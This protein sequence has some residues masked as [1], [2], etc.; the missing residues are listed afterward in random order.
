MAPTLSLWA[1]FHVI[2]LFSCLSSSSF[3][4]LKF[5][6]SPPLFFPTWIHLTHPIRCISCAA[7][8]QKPSLILFQ[9]GGLFC[10]PGKTPLS[11]PN[12]WAYLT[13]SVRQIMLK[14]T[15]CISPSPL[16]TGCFWRSGMASHCL[17]IH[18]AWYKSWLGGVGPQMFV[19]LNR[20]PFSH[21]EI[22]HA[23]N[24]LLIWSIFIY[25]DI[26]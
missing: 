8:F 24:Y 18:T 7:F 20:G 6:F 11:S 17:G 1:L 2:C 25:E 3:Y 19:S 4:W 10:P 12:P 5:P 23:W 22:S 15:V 26:I 14:V 9:V 21:P 13:L 16:D